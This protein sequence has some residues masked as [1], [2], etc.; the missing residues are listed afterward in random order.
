ML[1]DGLREMFLQLKTVSLEH[2]GSA[3]LVFATGCAIIGATAVLLDLAFVALRGKSLLKLQHGKNTILF[4][5]AWA[6]GSFA[7]GWVGQ[8]INLF[9]VSLSACVLVGFTWPILLTELLD[10]LR[11]EEIADEPEQSVFEEE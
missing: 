11:Q 10:K 1:L 4:V 3:V 8:L 2:N 6:F 5:F 7:I 9:Q